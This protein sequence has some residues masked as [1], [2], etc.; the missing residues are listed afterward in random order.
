MKRRAYIILLVCTILPIWAQFQ[1]VSGKETLATAYSLNASRIAFAAPEKLLVHTDSQLEQ[2]FQYLK[3]RMGFNGTVLVAE[4]HEIIHAGAYGYKQGSGGEA[5]DLHTTFQL[6]SVSKVITATAVLQLYDAGDIRDL[7]DPIQAYMPDFPYPDVTIHHMLIHRSGIPRYMPIAEARWNPENMLSNED[8]LQLMATDSQQPY[9]SAGGGFNYLNT[10]YAFLALL[11]ERLSGQSFGNYVKEHIFIPAGM[12]NSFVLDPAKELPRNVAI[13]HSR[14][15][16]GYRQIPF[17][18]L[19]GVVGDKGIF[20]NVIDLLRFDMALD[21]GRLISL[22]TRESAFCPGSPNRLYSNYGYGWRMRKQVDQVVYHFGW[23][24]GYRS[25][26]IKDITHGRT[27]IVLSNRDNMRRYFS[28]W[29]LMC[30]FYE[31]EEDAD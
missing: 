21:E 7:H 30:D 12:K 26:Y 6:A 2:R 19:D 23:W 18:M 3:N 17:D 16:R 13:G 31:G 4:G 22:D 5:L 8:M 11:V 27:I 28:P 14:M 1:F 25:A 9:F 24:R 20:S 29:E 15:R 10:N